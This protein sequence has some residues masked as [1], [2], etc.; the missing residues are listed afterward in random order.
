MNEHVS[1][2]FVGCAFRAPKI[3]IDK[4]SCQEYCSRPAMNNDTCSAAPC[5]SP[6]R[7]CPACVLQ[8]NPT[9]A[10]HGKRHCAFHAEHG[11]DV[12]RGEEH[13]PR[14]RPQPTVRPRTSF[15]AIDTASSGTLLTSVYRRPAEKPEW[16][17]PAPPAPPS[18]PKRTVIPAG[19]PLSPAQTARV[20]AVLSGTSRP[21][22]RPPRDETRITSFDPPGM[23]TVSELSFPEV[24]A[25][26]VESFERNGDGTSRT[27]V[28]AERVRSLFEAADELRKG[29]RRVTL[30]A[31]VLTA[32]LP[33]G[34]SLESAKTLAKRYLRPDEKMK[35]LMGA[36]SEKADIDPPVED[37]TP[38]ISEVVPPVPPGPTD[39]PAQ[40]HFDVHAAINYNKN[41]DGLNRTQLQAGRIRRLKLRATE[42]RA[43]GE[44]VTQT[45]LAE[46]GAKEF[47]VGKLSMY[48]FISSAL[49]PEEKLQMGIHVDKR[50]GRSVVPTL[51][52]ARNEK[53]TSADVG[54]GSYGESAEARDA[55]HGA[56]AVLKFRGRPVTVE[57]V[58]VLLGCSNERVERFAA[59][60]FDFEQKLD[61]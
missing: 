13:R 34:V 44:I 61:S 55:F 6:W 22:A 18:Q 9:L 17:K 7:F 31:V 41:P 10:E 28:Q 50:G 15:L 47:G 16:R 58:A 59:S 21:V 36:E 42:L 25:F 38:A 5:Q 48:N 35:L 46:W 4:K 45:V 26:K 2:S 11:A 29:N 52:A 54:P 3:G 37:E 8:R 19:M 1:A 32:S 57:N 30:S 49:H 12:I 56:A 14:P 23:T 60:H 39:S 20:T 24:E 40:E 33:W 53:S 27:P 51:A 43:A